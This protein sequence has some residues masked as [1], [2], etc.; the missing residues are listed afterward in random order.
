MRLPAY[1]KALLARRQAGDH[2]LSCV[3]SFAPFIPAPQSPEAF[4]T[5]PML[6]LKTSEYRRGVYDFRVLIGMRVVIRC[7]RGVRLRPLLWLTGE[8]GQH[9]ATV[10][11]E[12]YWAEPQ[13]ADSLAWRFGR[14]SG[15]CRWPRWWPLD[16]EKANRERKALWAGAALARFRQA[17]ER[18]AA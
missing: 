13:T 2:P 5:Q 11:I 9:A 15:I 14:A 18:R 17:E 7:G 10:T 1:G 6:A 4:Q 16:I 8:I 3:V 12:G